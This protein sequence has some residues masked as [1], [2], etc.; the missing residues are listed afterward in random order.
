MKIFVTG[1]SGFVGR[2][3]LPRLEDAGHVPTGIDREVD[4]TDSD[5]LEPAL[6]SHAPDA[7]IHLA[8][9]SSVAQS[10]REPKECFR[11]NLGGTRTLLRAAKTCCPDARI[12][13]IGSAD[14]YG[15]A[16]PREKGFD[17]SAPLRPISPYARS[18]ASA[19]LLG[20]QAAQLGQD[21]VRVRA[22]NHTGR[23]Q[24]D[25]FVA[26]SFAHQ[27][28]DIHLGR[29]EA[30]LRVGNLDSVR[31][32]LHVD[33]VLDAYVALLGPDVPADVYNIA[34]GQGIRIGDVLDQLIA[35]AGVDPVIETDPERFRPT[36]WSVGD[37]SRLRSVTDWAPKISLQ[38]ILKELYEDWLEQ[39]RAA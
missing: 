32:F 1:A 38:A 39:G 8:A 3:L 37:T 11:L 28:A 20:Q 22:F 25:H 33:D 14:Q 17:E 23:G 27:V 18:K 9:M 30:I 4:V 21:V 24:P 6:R 36:D 26:S 29:Q 13:L 5:S 19:E 16:E 10:W 12:L 31:D 2:K 35:I 15:T 34:S 7:I